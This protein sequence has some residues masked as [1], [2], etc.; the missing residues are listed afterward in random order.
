MLGSSGFRVV[1]P[2]MRGYNLSEKPQGWRNYGREKLT[3]DVAALIEALGAEKRMSSGMTGA[4]SSPGSRRSTARRSSTASSSSTPAI[5]FVTPR[6]CDAR[7]RC[8]SP[9][10][11]SSS[12]SRG[13]RKRS[14]ARETG[15]CSA[16]LS[17]TT[18][19][20]APSGRRRSERYI[21]TWSKP[22]AMKAQ[23]DYYRAAFREAPFSRRKL[24]EANPPIEAPTMVIWGENDRYGV[25]EVGHP[26]AGGGPQ[27]GAVRGA[28]GRVALGPAR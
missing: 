23:I 17:K 18:P 7:D 16:T 19:A 22:G 14:C 24:K 6:R 21:E 1:A 12:R 10:T 13:C 3:G 20:R 4:A 15:G 28:S 11:S 26:K 27:P 5:R 25:P 2:D 8:S 9:G